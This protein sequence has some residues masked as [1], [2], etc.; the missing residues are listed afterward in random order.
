M[1]GASAKSSGGMF[2]LKLLLIA[3][4]RAFTMDITVYL[5]LA[6]VLLGLGSWCVFVWAARSGQF[7]D[8]E[9]IKYRMLENEIK[10]TPSGMDPADQDQEK[11]NE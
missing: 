8:V 3:P 11:K 10:Q 4:A 7:R 1:H 5:V 2:P 9:D 6:A